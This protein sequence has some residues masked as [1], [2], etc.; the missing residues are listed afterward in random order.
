MFKQWRKKILGIRH[1]S[2]DGTLL[3]SCLTETA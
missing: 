3:T 2:D 1:F